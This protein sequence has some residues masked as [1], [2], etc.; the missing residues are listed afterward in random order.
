MS[1]TVSSLMKSAQRALKSCQLLID[2]EDYD[3]ACNRAYYAIYDAARAA[4]KSAGISDR[5]KT[6][7]G[8]I[9]VFGQ[10]LIKTGK[11]P[12]ELGRSISRVMNIRAASDY[13]GDTLG[14]DHSESALAEAKA[15][16]AAIEA[17]LPLS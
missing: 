12:A 13:D 17:A 10:H 14:V 9:T 3:G 6:H 8:L 15:F 1:S 11:L 4:L 16:I 2:D 7:S 5:T